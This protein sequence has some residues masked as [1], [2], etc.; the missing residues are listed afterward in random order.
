MKMKVANT[1]TQQALHK[2]SPNMDSK[3][4]FFVGYLKLV[5]YIPTNK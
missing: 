5:T 1:A 2:W 3:Q 4:T